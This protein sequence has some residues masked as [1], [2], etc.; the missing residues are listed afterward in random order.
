M[1]TDQVPAESGS[2]KLFARSATGLVREVPQRA[3][4]VFN[5]IPSHPALVLSAAVFFAF[6]LFPGGNFLFALVLDIPLV[7]AFAYSYGLLASMLPRTGGDYMF[8]TRIIHPVVGVISSVCW[9]VSLFMSNAFFALSFIKVGVA[10][11]L[12]IIGL[13]NGNSSM[14]RWGQTLETDTRWEFVVGTLMF[15]T[16]A[17][18]MA[19]GWRTTLRLQSLLFW[20]TV[21][22]ITACGLIAVFTSPSKFI[23][24]FNSFAGPH[25]HQADT[26]HATIAAAQ[27]AG[28]N[29]SPAFS[30]TNTIPLLGI[31]AIATI[32]PFISAAY[33]GELRQARS[34]RT[35]N[36]MALAGVGTLVFIGIFGA[37]FLHTFGTAFVI[38]ANSSTGLPPSIAASPTYFL[39]LSA[40]VGYTLV[41]VLLVLTY[42]VYWPLNTY[43][44]FMQQTRIF[45]AWA[46]DGLFP[47]SV[48]KVSRSH[49]PVM[50]LI[51]TVVISIGTLYWAVNSSSF[52]GVI[53]YATFLALIAMMLVGLSAAI[54]PWRRPEYYRA[55]ATQ[56]RVLGI[57]VV[58]ISGVAALA[59]GT[60]VWIMYLHY[61]Q[62]GVAH[63]DKMVEFVLGTV[64]SAVVFYYIA[65]GI[66]RRQGVNIELAYAEIPPE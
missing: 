2:P 16:A 48:T 56:H 3:A 38:A 26:Y 31:L 36:V 25:T 57:P 30:L 62:F 53:V 22:G 18:I 64:G 17:A 63:K 11:G 5:F 9:M 29:T 6:S 19:G 47:E 21:A 51:L 43:C 50:S 66:R 55:G 1:A 33:S 37:I 44:N 12:T 45:F 10:P 65:W 4:F 32:Y 42:A 28:V 52:L 60:F 59:A 13:L 41:A 34:V 7:L 46:F 20:I 40:S 27:H 61:P 15:L 49:S 23:H 54:V 24:N 35:A 58:T 14:V 39:L 8:V